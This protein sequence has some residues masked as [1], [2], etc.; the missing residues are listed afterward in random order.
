MTELESN[1]SCPECGR[2]FKDGSGLSAHLRMTH[3]TPSKDT[4]LKEY[5]DEVF[6]RILSLME[7]QTDKIM[8][9]DRGSTEIVCKDCGQFLGRNQAEVE[10]LKN[11]PSCGGIHAHTLK[12]GSDHR[13]TVVGRLLESIMDGMIK[14]DD[15]V[16]LCEDDIKG[17]EY[18]GVTPSKFTLEHVRKKDD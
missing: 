14:M 8:E 1:Y 5:I 9:I 17:L 16:K 2:N 6:G 4:D 15:R 11:C 10:K 18:I 3:R 13:F 12:D 7:K